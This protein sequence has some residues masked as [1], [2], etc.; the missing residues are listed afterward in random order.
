MGKAY[1]TH[2]EEHINKLTKSAHR[3][4][5]HTKANEFD[6]G[7]VFCGVLFFSSESVQ[8]KWQ[9]HND[10][11]TI[12]TSYTERLTFLDLTLLRDFMNNLRRQQFLKLS[13]QTHPL[14]HLL[15]DKRKRIVD[16]SDQFYHQPLQNLQHAFN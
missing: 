11:V 1:F 8:R 12:L 9:M 2:T 5:S 4:V 13:S 7:I 6:G 14:H 16:P 3:K 15:P 10:H